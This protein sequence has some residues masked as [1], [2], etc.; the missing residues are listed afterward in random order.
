ME[1]AFLATALPFL[2]SVAVPSAVV[3]N[4]TRT[5]SVAA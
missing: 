2:A 4:S 3:A 1:E 5:S